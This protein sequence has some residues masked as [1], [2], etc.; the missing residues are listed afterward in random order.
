MGELAEGG[1]KP[2]SEG[3]NVPRSQLRETLFCGQMS[4]ISGLS[5]GGWAGVSRF[6]SGSD[7]VSSDEESGIRNHRFPVQ[8]FCSYLALPDQTGMPT[9]AL[10]VKLHGFRVIGSEL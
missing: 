5:G 7:S 10:P 8:R 9:T 4:P 1:G 2:G 6:W 3:F